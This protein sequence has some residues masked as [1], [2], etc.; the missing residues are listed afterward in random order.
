MTEKELIRRCKKKNA[1]AQKLLYKQ[2][3]GSLLGICMRYGK[4]KAE[5]EDILQMAMMKIFKNIDSYSGKGSFEGWMKR[6]VVNMAVDNFRKNNIAK[7]SEYFIEIIRMCKELDLIRIGQINIDGTKIKANAVNRRTKTKE[8][9][10]QWVK[11]IDERIK[12]ILKEANQTDAEEDEL[13]GNKRGDKLPKGINTEEK[14]K[15]KIKEV[16]KKFKDGKEKIN[17]T[18]SEAKFMKT[19]NGSIDSSYNCQATVTKKQ[20]IVSIKVITDST[21]RKA[22]ELMIK[23]SDENLEKQVKEVAADAGYSSYDNYEYFVNNDKTGYIPDQNLRKDLR[24]GKNIYHQD[25]FLYK[26]DIDKYICPEGKLVSLS[27][28]D[29]ATLVAMKLV[30]FS[31]LIG[32]S[33]TNT[34]SSAFFGLIQS[35]IGLLD[36]FF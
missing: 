20:I 18:D 8:E 19:R 27:R 35:L 34:V 5:A 29:P 23:T 11:R 33:T 22:L 30:R 13:Y 3:H 24:A 2:F 12:K 21:D 4:S 7:L 16:M 17:L 1:K 31:P 10:Q 32:I 26:K 25:N 15:A 6:I 9:Y 14:L 28:C 36:Y